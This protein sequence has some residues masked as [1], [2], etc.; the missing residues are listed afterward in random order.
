MKTQRETQ[1]KRQ[2][3]AP[4]LTVYGSVRDITRSTQPTGMTDNASTG[5]MC[6]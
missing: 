1:E 4:R 3:C 6:S 2:Y 5:R